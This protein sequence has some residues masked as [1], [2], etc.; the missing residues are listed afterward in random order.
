MKQKLSFSVFALVLS[1]FFLNS[2][3]T[4]NQSSTWDNTRW[5]F[6]ISMQVSESADEYSEAFII[7]VPSSM[8]LMIMDA[9]N[10]DFFS[11]WSELKTM[12][13]RSNGDLYFTIEENRDI[14]IPEV[15]FTATYS[16]S[17][18]C[19]ITSVSDEEAVGDLEMSITVKNNEFEET[20]K[21]Q[22]YLSGSKSK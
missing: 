20:I 18:Y 15:D 16:Q 19:L 22:G 21:I 7:T 4:N 12:D 8:N 14:Y 11:D 10:G 2:C 13:L 17:G 1:L 6:D 3:Q 5:T 9:A